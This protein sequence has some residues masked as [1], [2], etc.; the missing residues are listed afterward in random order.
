MVGKC[1]SQISSTSAASPIQKPGHIPSVT[2][3]LLK[4]LV[5]FVRLIKMKT[6]ALIL[7]LPIIGFCLYSTF[8]FGNSILKK[9]LMAREI[10]GLLEPSPALGTEW[11]KI[12][13]PSPSDHVCV[14]GAGPSGVHM[15]AE[16]TK[17]N[18]SVT[19]LEKSNRIGGKSHDIDYRGAA[20]PQGT[21]F[22]EP[23]HFD[24][25]LPLAQEF[26]VGEYQMIPSSPVWMTNN[27]SDQGSKLSTSAFILQQMTQF[28]KSSSDEENLNFLFAKTLQ[29][30]RLH[31]ELFG[32]Y[33]GDLM[34]RPNA[35][36]MAR[37]EGTFLDF[38]QRED[39]Q[40]LE[41]LFVLSSTMQGYGQPDKVSSLYGLIWNNPRFLVA[42]ALNAI[43]QDYVPYSIFIMKD[44]FDKV[45]RTVVERMGIDVIFNVDITK[46][47]RG[48]AGIKLEM[49]TG[50]LEKE[51]MSCDWMVWTPPMQEMLK[52]L[53]QPTSEEKT[54]FKNMQAATFTTSL[55]NIEG[56]ARNGP[57][58]GYMKNLVGPE[59]HQVTA[60]FDMLGVKRPDIQ[61]TEGLSSYNG[62][63]KA[64]QTRAVVQMGLGPAS[65]EELNRLLREHYTQGFH[66]SKVDILHTNSHS[67]FPR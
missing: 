57:Y 24:D 2:E 37:L 4:N 10:I 60:D 32:T 13:G 53:D 63:I 5:I 31:K 39:L 55:I 14:V 30:I 6:F 7:A 20:Q 16:L 25:F 11:P 15:A 43:Q 61:T 38:L 40:A 64:S 9:F 54:L 42:I 56:A 52:V 3:K 1:D 48:E 12:P 58:Q 17:M 8:V 21:C 47:S 33:R 35:S 27:A 26:G 66:A 29:Y 50:K 45:W 36:V 46:V 28:T 34:L 44:G 23:N 65:K 62:D 18:Y 59:T 41:P 22:L 51:E 19:V 49:T 67:Y